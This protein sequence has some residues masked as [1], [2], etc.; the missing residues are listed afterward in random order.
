[1]EIFACR[2]CGHCCEGK[3]GI[4]L[5]ADEPGRIAGWLG[6]SGSR[7]QAEYCLESGG[8]LRLGTG[9]DGYCVFFLP[10]RG[11]SVHEVKPRVCRAWPFF[12]GN[13]V[14]RLSM[15]MAAE[16][17]PGINSRATFEEFRDYGLEYLRANALLAPQATATALRLP[18]EILRNSGQE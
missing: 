16:F 7:F 11:C 9:S 10:G 17:C 4:V 2:M 15:G 12:R 1:M 6:I 3:G 14:D 8:K 18:E 5:E 13:L